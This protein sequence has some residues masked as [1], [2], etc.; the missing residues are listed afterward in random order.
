MTAR[1]IFFRSILVIIYPL[2]A[3]VLTTSILHGYR[4]FAEFLTKSIK[5]PM[6]NSVG[7]LIVLCG[8]GLRCCLVH[9]AMDF[10]AGLV[11]DGRSLDSYGCA[12]HW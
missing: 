3:T 6:N 2:P 5:I 4:I 12:D 10:H 1:T 11:V 9:P 8:S 7:K